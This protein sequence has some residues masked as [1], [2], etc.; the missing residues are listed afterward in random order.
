[1]ERRQFTG[2]FKLEAVRLIRER[3]G[4]MRRRQK[5]LEEATAHWNPHVPAGTNVMF[6][7]WLRS[8]TV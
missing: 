7:T 8:I 1:M 3:G 5:T 6:L 4:R 2:E